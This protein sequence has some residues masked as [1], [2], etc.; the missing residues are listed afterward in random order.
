MN[1]RRALEVYF[2][3]QSLAYWSLIGLVIPIAGI[4]LASLSR[5]RLHMLRAN[6][7]DDFA[8]IEHVSQVAAWGLGLSI[9]ALVLQVI[10]GI[11]LGVSLASS[12]TNQ[13]LEQTPSN[14]DS[15]YY[16]Q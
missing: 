14:T 1:N 3:A 11:V 2:K 4:I 8:D 5:S 7:E 12:I 10:A 16:T 6:D 15:S 13:Q 9:G